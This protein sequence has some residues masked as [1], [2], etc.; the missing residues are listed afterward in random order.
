MSVVFKVIIRRTC[1]TRS[2]K[3]SMMITN[4]VRMIGQN[5]EADETGLVRR[6]LTFVLLPSALVHDL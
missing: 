1:Q 6:R 3:Q 4:D 5:C 2:Q